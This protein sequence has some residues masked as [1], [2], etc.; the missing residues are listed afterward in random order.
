[1]PAAD[2]NQQLADAL[3]QAKRGPMRFAFVI[4]GP[5]EGTLL[6]ARKSIPAKKIAEAKKEL[7]GGK[8]Y[9][10]RCEGEMG[11]LVCEV[12]QEPPATL[13]K[14]LKALIT[15]D[16]GPLFKAVEFR[17]VADLAEEEE[18]EAPP[19][20]VPPPPR[21]PSPP[22]DA[23]AAVLKRLSALAGPYQAAVA[24]QGPDGA[25]MQS[26]F[27]A[28]KGLVGNQDFAQAGKVLDELEPLVAGAQAAPAGAPSGD[29][30]ARFTAR[31]KAL[32]PQIQQAQA[33]N[34][35]VGQEV[36]LR[37]SEANT[38]ARKLDF[39][40]ANVLLDRVEALLKQASPTA[41][42]PPPPPPPPTGDGAARFTARLK[43]LMPQIQQAQAANSPAS[44]EIKVRASEANTLARKKDFVQ[45][46]A[47]LDKIEALLKQALGTGGADPA[48]EWKKNLAAWTPAIKAALAAKGPDA[49]A[50]AKLFSQAS[51]LSK[52]GGDMALALEKLTECHNL[53]TAGAA[54]AG[55][56]PAGDGKTAVSNVVFT[57]T[58]LVWDATRKKVQTELEALAQAIRTTCRQWNEDP[59]FEDEVDPNELEA[60]LKNLNRILDKLDTRLIDKLDEALNAADPAQRQ[61]KH[62]EAKGLV[63]E[64]LAFVNTDPLLAEI[65]DNGFTATKVRATVLAALTAL[66]SKL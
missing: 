18:G 8:V 27:G 9:R 51:A 58:R 3:K 16:V 15:R 37:A 24:A 13:A 56:A 62:V 45:A 57:Q 60:G 23:R 33:G 50:I 65:D 28:V 42:P 38:F 14:Q 61:A 36:K 30:A 53:A 31:L 49:P 26:L 66:S 5:A 6:V 2:A 22:G 20:G 46:N 21:P 39:A 64:Y 48:A 19:E 12:A 40:Q 43:A 34:S 59:N 17:V 25:R 44:Q 11:A 52:P 7:G 47:V 32:L 35:P 29:G 41:A 1:M 10:G 54:P 4:K 63:Q 55:A